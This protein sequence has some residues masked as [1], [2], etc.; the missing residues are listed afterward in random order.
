MPEITV[1]TRR[2]SYADIGPKRGTRARMIYEALVEQGD[3]TAEELT[4]LLVKRGDIPS[5][6]LNY[7]RPRLTE[8]KDARMVRAEGKRPSR[9]SGKDTAVWH[10]VR[11]EAEG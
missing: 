1:E 8:M 7:V 10:A 2:K 5:F 4:E 3:M 6:D 9:H 11:E